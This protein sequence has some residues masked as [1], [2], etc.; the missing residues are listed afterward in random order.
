MTTYECDVCGFETSIKSNYT[1]HT[2]S[3]RHRLVFEK[4]KL[5][6]SQ[7]YS[8]NTCEYKSLKKSDYN[9]HLLSKKHQKNISRQHNNLP[10]DNLIDKVKTDVKEEVND[11][12]KALMN[13]IDLLEKQNNKNTNTIVKEARNMKK[14][15]LTLL[16]THFKDSP[17]IEYIQEKPFLVE[18]EKEYRA[19]VNDGTD[20]I[21]MRIFTDYEKKK[22]V[23]TLSDLIL[24]FVKKDQQKFQ[25]VFNIDAARSNFATK[26][27]D[28]WLNDKKGLQLRK[29]TIDKVI[30][31]MI[32]VLEI[33]RLQLVKIREKNME[34]PT[35]ELSD[36]LMKY[37]YLLLEVVSFLNHPSTHTKIITQ[38]SPNLRCEEQLFL[39]E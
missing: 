23:K 7:T 30:N 35:R 17:S 34:N 15:I 37:Q 6:K 22:L 9:R 25:S 32:D 36:Y 28:F 2:L 33:F 38:L 14:S 24:K 18:L 29:F 12:I 4:Y 26:I 1:R 5:L 31:F 39:S 21:F 8:C 16:N 20:K 19:K 13:K 11:T 27:D 3:E 10:I